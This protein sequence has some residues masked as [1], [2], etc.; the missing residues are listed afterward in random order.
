[1]T[2]NLWVVQHWFDHKL[3]WDPQDF[4]GVSAVGGGENLA[5]RGGKKKKN[6]KFSWNRRNNDMLR[7]RRNWS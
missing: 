7:R 5:E 6:G 1:M 2:T 3:V 4:G